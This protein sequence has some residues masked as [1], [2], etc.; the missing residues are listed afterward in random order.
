[1]TKLFKAS[2]LSLILLILMQAKA[3]AS[4][5]NLKG[6]CNDF[7]NKLFPEMELVGLWGG[8]MQDF[9]VSGF[10]IDLSDNTPY[11]LKCYFPYSH[12]SK[13]ERFM[14]SVF[15]QGQENPISYTYEK[16]EELKA[17]FEKKNTSNSEA[18]LKALK[19]QK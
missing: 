13:P 6:V 2:T 10:L 1:M 5:G 14:L 8:N 18:L 15:G 16:F 12:H 17:R 9:N 4:T 19:N 11:Q 7:I 3:S